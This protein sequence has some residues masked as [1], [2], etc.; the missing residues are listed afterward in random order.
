MRNQL[1]THRIFAENLTLL[2]ERIDNKSRFCAKIG[3]N[4]AQL[5]RYMSGQSW[6][7][8]HAAQA[9]CDHFGV[10]ARIFLEPLSELNGDL[11][12]LLNNLQVEQNTS[13]YQ[14]PEDFLPNGL[15]LYW[16]ESFSRKGMVFCQMVRIFKRGSSKC[17]KAFRPKFSSDTSQLV[18]LHE[19]EI[20]GNVLMHG[21][22]LCVMLV[23]LYGSYLAMYSLKPHF[24]S[25]KYTFT[26]LGMNAVALTQS[27]AGKQIFQHVFEYISPQPKHIM[28]AARKQ[29][30]YDKP[31]FD[32][33]H[34]LLRADMEAPA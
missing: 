11:T 14:V 32:D 28:R 15:Y 30:F 13:H 33:V 18:S 10:D 34:P 19:R 16:R 25:T 1:A 12:Y 7:K 22:G 4:R 8:P 26:G 31:Q 20:N 21:N 17:W 9:I 24:N 29:G 6:P 27:N 2:M 5:S 23:D 3:I